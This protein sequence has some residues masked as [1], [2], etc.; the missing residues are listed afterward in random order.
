MPTI[1][2]INWHMYKMT[3]VYLVIRFSIVCKDKGLEAT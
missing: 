2:P 1:Y 3:F